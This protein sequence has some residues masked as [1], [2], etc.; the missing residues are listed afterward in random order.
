MILVTFG[1]CCYGLNFGQGNLSNSILDS[2]IR[3]IRIQMN[4]FNSSCWFNNTEITSKYNPKRIQKDTILMIKLNSLLSDTSKSISL[5]KKLRMHSINYKYH[6]KFVD[7][8]RVDIFEIQNENLIISLEQG[9]LISMEIYMKKAIHLDST[10]GT[11]L[12]MFNTDKY[13]DSYY[14]IKYVLPFINYYFEYEDNFLF[15]NNRRIL[16]FV[17]K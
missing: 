4:D 7:K 16:M 14:L 10:C 9:V 17:N 8:T 15:I 12:A 2:N 13:P 6:S 5:K 11:Y 1:I 3:M